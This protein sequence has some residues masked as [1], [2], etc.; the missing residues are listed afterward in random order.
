[1]SFQGD[2]MSAHSGD[3]IWLQLD[4]EERP[5]ALLDDLAGSTK[6]SPTIQ[7]LLQLT[8]RPDAQIRP[9]VETLSRSPSLAAEVLK[10]ANC[11]IYAHERDIVDLKRAVVLIGMQELHAMAAG[12]SMLA[13][14][15]SDNEIASTMRETSVVSATIARQLAEKIG[16]DPVDAFLCGLLCEI[17][18]L[19]V[20]HRDG[21]GYSKIWTKSNSSPDG[22]F[23][24]ESARY[25]IASEKTGGRLL[26]LNGLPKTV[27]DAICVSFDEAAT[28]RNLL[29]RITCFARFAACV[30]VD[31]GKMNSREIL[32]TGITRLANHMN[33]TTPPL[34]A[35]IKLCLEAGMQANLGL[36]GQANLYEE[37]LEMQNIAA[38][39]QFEMTNPIRIDVELPEDRRRKTILIAVIMLGIVATA[40]A[41]SVVLTT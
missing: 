13:M 32:E 20:N 16:Q 24:L 29:G 41:V 35:L 17:G 34:P 15:S 4:V 31:A 38:Q 7:K 26:N 40:V 1:M 6:I 8:N 11:P 3:P 14:F 19:A 21:D 18:A 36:R 28:T 22:R 5:Q 33:I 12:L 37:T 25:G 23:Q 9:V 27:A 39:K 10:V 30:L 2:L